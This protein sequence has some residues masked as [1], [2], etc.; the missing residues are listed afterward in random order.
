MLRCY[1]EHLF[2][3]LMHFFKKMLRRCQKDVGEKLLSISRQI[4]GWHTEIDM[5]PQPHHVLHDSCSVLG[6]TTAAADCLWLQREVRRRLKIHPGKAQIG[7]KCVLTPCT[8]QTFW[9]SLFA[10]D[11]ILRGAWGGTDLR[12][13]WALPGCILNFQRRQLAAAV[14][15]GESQQSLMVDS[16]TAC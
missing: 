6:T 11:K 9:K 3:N 8:P 7:L 15:C 2:K 14:S 13:F 10:S 4:S 5:A 1:F 16:R 12:P